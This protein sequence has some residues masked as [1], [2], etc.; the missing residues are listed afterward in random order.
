M[1]PST[2]FQAATIDRK[3]IFVLSEGGKDL[4]IA[5]LFSNPYSL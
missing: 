5:V 2:V 1:Y 4:E 3:R